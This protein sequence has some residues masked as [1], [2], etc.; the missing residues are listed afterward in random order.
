MP[1]I[2]DRQPQWAAFRHRDGA[3]GG[4]TLMAC[5]W[6][7]ACHSACSACSQNIGFFC[8]MS[9]N[10]P[11]GGNAV[12]LL[13]LLPLLVPSVAD[14]KKV[15]VV[16]TRTTAKK[17]AAVIALWPESKMA[18]LQNPASEGHALP[19]GHDAGRSTAVRGSGAAELSLEWRARV[20]RGLGPRPVADGGDCRDHTAAD[21]LDA[22]H[23][24]KRPANHSTQR[25]EKRTP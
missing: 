22:V 23:P 4:H 21:G 11:V 3:L 9:P 12:L 19:G 20:I 7:L 5:H 25:K 2:A 17:F 6:I 16:V 18:S 14:R 1:S 10:A 8:P 15:D 24:C 13:A